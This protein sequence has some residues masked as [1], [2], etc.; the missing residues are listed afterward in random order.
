MR[1]LL[2]EDDPTLR[3]QLRT[4]LHEAGYAVD[5]AD[6]GRD[7]HFLGETEAFDAVVLDLG[8]PVLDGLSVLKRWRDAGSVVPVLILTARDNWSEKVAGIDAGADDYLTKPFHMEELL[9]RLRALIRRAG[10]LASPLLVCGELALD[11]RSGRVAL[12]GQTVALTSHEYKVLEYLMHRPGAVVS[13]TELTEHIYAQDFERDSNTIEV[14]VGRL[15]KKLP[16]A[17]IETVRGLGY[18]LVPTP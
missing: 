8:L 12:Q 16:P 13:R 17:L 6:N 18:R 4:G 11:T 5:E 7:A 2:V 10:G 15:R 1:I 9:A 14:F 3:A